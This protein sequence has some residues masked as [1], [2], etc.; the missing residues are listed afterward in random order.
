M[1]V[2]TLFR[3]GIGHEMI[4]VVHKDD[5]QDLKNLIS[6]VDK[7]LFTAKSLCLVNPS[8]GSASVLV[9]GAD[10]DLV[11]DDTLIDIRG[12]FRIRNLKYVNEL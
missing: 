7:K 2:A 10:T 12:S 1:Q 9:G 8:F 3:A 5:V 4:G 11:M 6:V